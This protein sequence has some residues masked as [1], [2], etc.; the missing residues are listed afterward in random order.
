MLTLVRFAPVTASHV[1]LRITDGRAPVALHTF[2][3]YR[4]PAA[5]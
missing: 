5:P 4:A 1:R 3:I 2:G